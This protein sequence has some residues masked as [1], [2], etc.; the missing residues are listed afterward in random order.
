M[1]PLIG[2]LDCCILR[3]FKADLWDRTAVSTV[4]KASAAQ[5]GNAAAEQIREIVVDIIPVKR[6]SVEL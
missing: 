5:A 2:A 3:N 4:Y 1:Q 6:C